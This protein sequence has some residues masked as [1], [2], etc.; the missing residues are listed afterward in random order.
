MNCSKC[1]QITF[2]STLDSSEIV[3]KLRA[4]DNFNDPL[5]QKITNQSTIIIR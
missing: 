4:N 2:D 1:A 5:K 3:E